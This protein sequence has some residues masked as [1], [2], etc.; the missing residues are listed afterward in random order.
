MI[1]TG[2]NQNVQRKM[3]SHVT[4]PTTGSV[5]ET[6]LCAAVKFIFI[7]LLIYLKHRHIQHSLQIFTLLVLAFQLSKLQTYSLS[8]AI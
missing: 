8:T 5:G 2:E 7:Y 3:C 6:C 1:L 4:F